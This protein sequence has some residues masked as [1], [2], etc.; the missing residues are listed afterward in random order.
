[1]T[2][3]LVSA[4]RLQSPRAHQRQQRELLKETAACY[5][6]PLRFVL[7]MYP[8]GRGVLQ[9]HD[10]PDAWQTGFLRWLGAEVQARGFDGSK[11]VKPIRKA[12]SKGHGV[13]GSTLAAFLVDWIMS[14]RPHAQGTVTANTITQLQT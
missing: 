4:P 8:W 11:A 10:G 12:V 3:A 9:H 5:A 13:G 7:T 1:M 6:D 14:T 2:T